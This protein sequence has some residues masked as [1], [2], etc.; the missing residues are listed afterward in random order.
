MR[1]VLELRG[2][3]STAAV[4]AEADRT[5]QTG[6]TKPTS[7][8]PSEIARLTNELARFAA[9]D[10]ARADKIDKLAK[11]NA[12]LVELVASLTASL[13]TYIDTPVAADVTNTLALPPGAG[14]LLYHDGPSVPSYCVTHAIAKVAH[15]A[16]VHSQ[17]LEKAQQRPD[18]TTT[19]EH[20]GQYAHGC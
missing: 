3:S 13:K 17:M 14:A 6:P 16:L 2:Q 4:R 10:S 18:S 8:S 20:I 19:R 15:V 11:E 1:T 5:L 12:V 7:D 9:E